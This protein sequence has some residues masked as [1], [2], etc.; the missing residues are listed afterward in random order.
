MQYC[1]YCKIYI[2]GKKNKCV[3]CGNSIPA[4]HNKEGSS[5]DES[6]EAYPAIPPS[7]QRHLALRIM[8]FI[9]LTVVVISFTA[10]LMFPT[11]INW[12]LLIVYGLASTWLSL[13][14]IVKKRHNIPKT[15]IWQVV[16]MTLLSLFWDWQTGW[17]GWSVDYVI[18]ITYLAAMLVM[19]VSARI[20]RLSVR[21]YIT[22]ALLDGIFGII[23]VAFIL[24]DWARV[25]FPSI[26][27]AASSL[28]FLAAIF[29]FH[30]ESIKAELNK[31]MHI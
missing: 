14:A 19:Y 8:V 21:D 26:I 28:V 2:R 13:L 24:F 25:T 15:I 29:I 7:F 31:R 3:L 1:N 11:D 23:P 17:M 6:K 27:C 22:Y 12:P 9:S 4:A 30:G 18:P 5:E 16:I 10:Y 20:M